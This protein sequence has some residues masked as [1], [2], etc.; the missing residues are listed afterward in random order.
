MLSIEITGFDEIENTLKEIEENIESLSGEREVNLIELFTNDFMA[1]YT[2]NQSFE[3]FVNNFNKD[4]PDDDFEKMLSTEDWN[5]Y[6]IN[7]SQFDS[8][9]DMQENAVGLYYSKQLGF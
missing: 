3:E 9:K 5:K 4:I 2:T 7:N 6:V 8:W 1:K